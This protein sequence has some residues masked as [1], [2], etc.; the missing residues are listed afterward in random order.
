[1][2][3][4][5]KDIADRNFTIGKTLKIETDFLQ[6]LL[7][8][9][10][11]VLNLLVSEPQ[12]SQRLWGYRMPSSNRKDIAASF[13]NNISFITFLGGIDMDEGSFLQFYSFQIFKDKGIIYPA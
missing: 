13:S 2:I 1:M 7:M 11:C 9:F 8:H 3:A 10:H 6:L 12:C 5:V 4:N